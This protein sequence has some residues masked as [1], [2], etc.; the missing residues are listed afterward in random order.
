MLSAQEIRQKYFPIA[1]PYEHRRVYVRR[2]QLPLQF[3]SFL[4]LLETFFGCVS[5]CIVLFA[6]CAGKAFAHL[7]SDFHEK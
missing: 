2:A 4:P 5:E 1:L 7:E 3:N 6:S